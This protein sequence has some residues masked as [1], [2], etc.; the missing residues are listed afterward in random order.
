MELNLGEVNEAVAAAVGDRECVVWGEKRFTWAEFAERSRRFAN[1]LVGEGLGCHTE[2]SELEGWES[3][4][5]HLALY[6]T[7]G[8]EYLE[9]MVGAYKARVAPF[10]VNYRYVA[11]EL[12][13]LLADARSTAIV[14]SGAFAQT[15]A[16]VRDDLPDLRVLIQ[17]DDG[18]GAELLPGAVAYEDALAAASPERPAV[19]P[20]PDDLYILYTGGTTG[21]P[22][23]VLWRQADIG[24]SALGLARD[25]GSEFESL[26][27]VVEAATV[28]GM[29][30]LPSPP[31]MHG[32]GHW[33]A[34]RA[35]HGG[36]T[37]VIQP[38]TATLDPDDVWSTVERERISFLLIVGDA[39]GQPLLDQLDRRRAEGRPYDLS[40][41]AII[42]SGGAALSAP[43]KTRFLDHLPAVMVVDGVGSSEAGGQ[44]SHVSTKDTG[45]STGTFTPAPGS[46]VLDDTM[47][48]VLD[49]GHDGDGWLAK[50][51]R[52][53]LG[54]LG[55][56]R[57][58]ESTFPTVDGNRWSVPGDRARLRADGVIELL[59]RDSVTIN[60]GGEK[61]F[62]EEV[63]AALRNH[64]DVYDCVVC[65]R[66][67]ERWGSEVVAVVQLREGAT[68]DPDALRATCEQH[69]ARYKVPKA[70]VFQS[71]IVRSPA[72]K[73][74]YR[75]AK[76]VASG[77]EVA[78]G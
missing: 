67:S 10:N 50:G 16:E 13:Y 59:G 22:K 12:R 11:E 46:V 70:F 78:S 8:N 28:G 35:L 30:F 4:Q 7:N 68:P 57:K 24:V 5:D 66:P 17:V 54:Y 14:Y 44:M 39:F 9:A 34:L 74:D 6:L 65:G 60:S 26:D 63:E 27:A 19:E 32:A 49:A 48:K 42:L 38:N 23:G 21:M 29:R 77:D 40:S 45:A 62:V 75:W 73:A 71:A 36:H 33:I 58:S 56:E 64:A 69:I 76:S 52:I 15:L 3:G 53:P 18:S 2:R 1:H 61:I 72:G 55:D 31:F 43:L 37:V 51:G 41:L 20:S 47:E 25:D